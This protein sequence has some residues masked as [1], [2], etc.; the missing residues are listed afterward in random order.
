MLSLL[1][2]VVSWQGDVSGLKVRSG[3]GADKDKAKHHV[4]VTVQR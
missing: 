3:G 1:G 4:V 2:A